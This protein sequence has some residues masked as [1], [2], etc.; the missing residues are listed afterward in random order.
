MKILS[1]CTTEHTAMV[2]EQISDSKHS[3]S[4]REEWTI[5]N[6]KICYALSLGNLKKVRKLHCSV[7]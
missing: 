1:V 2:K 7:H 4:V 5:Q 6:Y 3:T